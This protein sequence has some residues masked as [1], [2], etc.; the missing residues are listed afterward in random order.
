MAGEGLG[1]R[2]HVFLRHVAGEIPGLA[3][4]LRPREP[5]AEMLAHVD[6][7]QGR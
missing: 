5:A 2:A 1:G 6:E 3:C 4:R 7:R